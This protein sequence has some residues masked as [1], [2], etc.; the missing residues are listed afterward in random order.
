ML[1]NLVAEYVPIAIIALAL[2]FLF[3]KIYQ[4]WNNGLQHGYVRIFIDSLLI[5]PEQEIKNT[6]YAPLKQY[7]LSSNKVNTMFYITLASLVFI[8]FFISY[9]I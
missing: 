3:I 2:I 7:Y 6:F 1:Q 4:I 8:Y 5:F 9:F